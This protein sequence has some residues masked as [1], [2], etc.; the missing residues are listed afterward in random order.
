MGLII[1]KAPFRLPLGGG[2]TDL[3]SYY[4]QFGGQLITSSIN[5]YMYVFINEPPIPDK[6]KLH[7]S[8]LETVTD[9]SKIKHNIIRESLKLFGIN[10]PIEITSMADFGAGT[11]MGSSSAFTVALLAGLH[12]LK[13]ESPI[14]EFIA[15]EACKVEMELVGSP[16]GKQ[17]QYASALGGINEL[18]IDKNGVVTVNILNLDKSLIAELE[19]RFIMFYTGITRDANK[20]LYEEGHKITDNDILDVMHEIKEIGIYINKGLIGGNIDYIGEMLHFHWKT[21]MLIT[22]KMSS[23]QIDEW[24]DLAINNGAIGG[25]VM[26]AGGGGL[27]LFCAEDGRQDALK[28]TMENA[29]LKYI[30]FKFEF[31]GVKIIKND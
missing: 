25:K 11:G 8:Q 27:F 21:K 7:Y 23:Y 9:V 19:N 3:P 29:G 5:K 4:R 18:I 1:S 12:E 22:S 15:E 20:I 30:D 24:Y 2:G 26:G 31:D 28:L 13:G 17:D 6:I 10:R 16:I 14:A